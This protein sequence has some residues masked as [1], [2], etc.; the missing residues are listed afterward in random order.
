VDIREGEQ[1]SDLM[2]ELI[3]LAE[4]LVELTSEQP[5]INDIIKNEEE[6]K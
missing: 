3:V 6:S 4:R 1:V 2:N 5:T